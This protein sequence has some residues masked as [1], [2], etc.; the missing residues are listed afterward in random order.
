MDDDEYEPSFEKT[1][2]Q[3]KTA[4]ELITLVENYIKNLYKKIKII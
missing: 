3:I 4:Q 2:Q 1:E